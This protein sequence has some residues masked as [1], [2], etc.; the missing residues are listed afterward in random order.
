MSLTYST[1]FS[2]GSLLFKEALALLKNVNDPVAL[3][4]GDEAPD[5]AAIPVNAESSKRRLGREVVKRFQ[6]I[7][8]PEFISL[9]LRGSKEEQLLILFYAACKTYKLIADFLLETVLRKWQHLDYEINA[10]D[11][12]NFLYKKMDKS[13][14]LE[15]M[16][17]TFITKLSSVVIR[18][19]NESGMLKNGKLQKQNYSPVVLKMIAKNGDAWFL[20]AILLNE[21][22]INEIIS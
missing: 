15:S 2:A 4:A 8:N 20:Q 21:T 9:Y 14:K 7:E 5:L 13:P 18:M 22:E 10:D 17:P 6:S 12:K 3:L 16:S 19:L 11:F 1:A